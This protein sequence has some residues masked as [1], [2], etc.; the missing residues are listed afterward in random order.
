MPTAR[1]Y[2]ALVADVSADGIPTRRYR[3]C[4]V[5][6]LESCASVSATCPPIA[7]RINSA[8]LNCSNAPRG[9]RVQRAYSAHI[10]V[11]L[12]GDFSGLAKGNVT[13]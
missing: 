12:P 13:I 2:A 8:S 7:I 4:S 3:K 10:G 6:R 5:N 11:N 1:R 9:R